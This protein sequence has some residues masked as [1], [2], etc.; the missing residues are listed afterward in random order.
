[1]PPADLVLEAVVATAAIAAVVAPMVWL[2][3]HLVER[4]HPTSPREP[5]TGGH[6]RPRRTRAARR[7][8][9]R[10]ND[11]ER[12]GW[13]HPTHFPAQGLPAP[14]HHDLPNRWWSAREAPTT[15]RPERTTA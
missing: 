13:S 6:R 12:R 10:F 8:R 11:G 5:R 14:G 15:H 2:A 1:V 3:D 4:L 7:P 9:P